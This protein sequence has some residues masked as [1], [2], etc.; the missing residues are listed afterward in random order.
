MLD[1]L[2]GKEYAPQLKI[3]LVAR[4]DGNITAKQ[5]HD[6]GIYANSITQWAIA[7]EVTAG[8]LYRTQ[9]QDPDFQCDILA[10]VIK[11]MDRVDLSREPKEILIYLYRVARHATMDWTRAKNAAKRAHEEVD[12]ADMVATS[13]FYGKSLWASAPAAT[14]RS[15]DNFP[16]R[17]ME[18]L[19]RYAPEFKINL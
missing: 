18:N 12:F 2:T 5:E 13:N 6:L 15:P 8:K 17:Q 14:K 11:Y 1:N 4:K 9:S 3:V 16:S 7:S 10:E 19:S